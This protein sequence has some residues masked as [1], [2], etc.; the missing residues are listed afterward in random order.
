MH[1]VNYLAQT[2]DYSTLIY[3]SSMYLARL[4]E[5]VPIILKVYQDPIH[6]N[7]YKFWSQITIWNEALW[8]WLH[9]FFIIFTSWLETWFQTQVT[10]TIS[11]KPLIFTVTSRNMYICIFILNIHNV[12]ITKGII[13]LS[14]THSYLSRSKMLRVTKESSTG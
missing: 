7:K 9:I 4:L 6:P 1:Y 2:V 8:K 12:G 10:L 11:A 13:L 14:I 3:Q 5:K